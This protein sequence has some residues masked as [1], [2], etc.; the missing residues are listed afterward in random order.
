MADA[1]TVSTEPPPPAGPEQ[2]GQEDE[3]TEEDT[4]GRELLVACQ[5]GDLQR[6]QSLL[7]EGAPAYY[8]VYTSCVLD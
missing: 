7:A 4:K 3:E 5:A 8:Q 6:V 2:Q 1:H